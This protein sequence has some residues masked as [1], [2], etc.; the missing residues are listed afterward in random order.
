MKGLSRRVLL[1]VLTLTL[2]L[3]VAPGDASADGP[4]AGVTLISSA[5]GMVGADGESQFIQRNRDG[6]VLFMSSASNLPG[7]VG[8]WEAY[9]WTPDDGVTLV[10]N[11]GTPS[12]P[13]GSG[14]GVSKLWYS[15]LT[16][17]SD[18]GSVVLVS[19]GLG[20]T[21]GPMSL[22]VYRWTRADGLTLVSNA[23]TVEDPRGAAGGLK[24]CDDI[25]RYSRPTING[26]GAILFASGAPDLPG[27]NCEPGEW[28]YSQVYLWSATDGLTLVSNVGTPEAPVGADGESGT[29]IL[30]DDGSVFFTSSAPGLPGGNGIEQVY[31]WTRADGVT[32]VTNVGSAENPVGATDDPNAEYYLQHAEWLLSNGKDSLTFSSPLLGLPGGNGDRQV[33]LWTAADGLA[34]ITNLGTPD[35]PVGV[36]GYWSAPMVLGDDDTVLFDSNAADLPGSTATRD[37]FTNY[38]HYLWTRAHGIT[39]ITNIGTATNPVGVVGA[40]G[41]N[42]WLADG[43]AVM[44][45][46]TAENL[47][48][49][50]GSPQVYHWTPAGGLALVSN[51]GTSAAPLAAKHESTYASWTEDDKSIT[52]ISA[53]SNLP[54]AA[55]STSVYRWTASDGLTAVASLETTDSKSWVQFQVFADGAVVLT[56]SAA[57]L[58]G[59]NGIGQI[60]LWVSSEAASSPATGDMTVVILAGLVTVTAFGAA[61]SPGVRSRSKKT[62]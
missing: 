50:D 32:L 52:F 17:L 60:Y 59:A 37:S 42:V 16:E 18:D 34:L 12:S 40:A 22:Q 35:A 45:V 26:K 61:T 25:G 7:S 2:V 20:F 3:G 23:G 14:Y 15:W 5:D 48:G 43:D 4:S 29:F 21:D 19:G 39:L 27:A 24:G 51:A 49:A 31:R 13:L 53:A 28:C 46:S 9:V 41:G 58:L 54:G 36:R 33:Y 44:F 8:G 38:Q 62:T 10:T 55:G 30:N 11:I 6:A 47:P 57:G 56:S 1:S